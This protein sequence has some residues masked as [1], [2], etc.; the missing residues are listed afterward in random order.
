MVDLTQIYLTR[1]QV[2]QM[3]PISV[4]TLA[5]LASEGRGPVFFKPTDKALYRPQDVE[6]WIEAAPVSVAQPASEAPARTTGRGR[7]SRFV[8]A[9][10]TP[11]PPKD[12]VSPSTGRRLRSLTPSPESWL[13]RN[14]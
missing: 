9:T 1:R 3:Y 2:S 13:R 4:H 7:T 5:K 14:E 6:K 12:V 10:R 8:H 11:S